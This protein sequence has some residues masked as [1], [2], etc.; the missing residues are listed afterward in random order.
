MQMETYKIF[1]QHLYFVHFGIFRVK[2]TINQ[3]KR[4]NLVIEKLLHYSAKSIHGP[5]LFL[6]TQ[7]L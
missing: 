2:H 7:S 6:N 4:G 1:L 5:F 3:A